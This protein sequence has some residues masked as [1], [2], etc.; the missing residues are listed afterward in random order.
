MIGNHK[1]IGF[2]KAILREKQNKTKP[3]NW[4]YHPHRSQNILHS[5][6]QNS[7]VLEKQ[8]KKQKQKSQISETEYR[9]QKETHRA[10]TNLQ[11][12]T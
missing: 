7:S 6:D 8:K 9:A 3:V 11:Q 2:A 4:R 5:H 12:R 10:L 1:R